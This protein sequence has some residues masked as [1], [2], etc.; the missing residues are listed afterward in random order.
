MREI[1][2]ERNGLLSGAGMNVPFLHTSAPHKSQCIDKIEY[3]LRETLFDCRSHYPPQP[4]LLLSDGPEFLEKEFSFRSW[5]HTKKI[6]S[7][8][9]PNLLHAYL[10]KIESYISLTEETPFSRARGII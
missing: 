5:P 6:H 8:F 3:G 4:G 1:F 9:S 7:I 10:F 2:R